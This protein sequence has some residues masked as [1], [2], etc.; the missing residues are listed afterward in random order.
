[1]SQIFVVFALFPAHIT[2]INSR[3]E[4]G[5]EKSVPLENVPREKIFDI[6]R[7]LAAET[8]KRA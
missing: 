5:V 3:Y 7:N 2:L 1:M 4:Y 8:P 6:V